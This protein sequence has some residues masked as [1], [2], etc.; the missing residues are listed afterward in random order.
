MLHRIHLRPRSVKQPPS[1]T[2]NKSQ[3]QHPTGPCPE[4]TLSSVTAPLSVMNTLSILREWIPE[5]HSAQTLVITP[6]LQCIP[7]R[8][9]FTPSSSVETRVCGQSLQP[10]SLKPEKG[11]SRLG[12]LWRQALPLFCRCPLKGPVDTSFWARAHFDRP[13]RVH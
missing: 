5:V 11:G 6:V 13:D 1:I 2:S 3:E 9:G 12:M 7:S 8:W 4:H 10:C